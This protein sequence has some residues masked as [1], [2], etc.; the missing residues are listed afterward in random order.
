[1]PKQAKLWRFTKFIRNFIATSEK[2]N[3]TNIPTR[4]IKISVLVAVNPSNK[5]FTIFKNEAPSIMGIA[6]KKENSA[7]ATRE[8]PLSIPPS[9][10]EPD[11]EVP[12]IRESI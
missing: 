3:E 6:I 10:V 5:N 1:M 8:T 12:G 4:R 9:I 11:L 2:K 7:L